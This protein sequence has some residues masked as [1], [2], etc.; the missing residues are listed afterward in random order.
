MDYSIEY[1]VDLCS[2]AVIENLCGANEDVFIIDRGRCFKGTTR[3]FI[4]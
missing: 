1:F 4:L 2:R 3:V